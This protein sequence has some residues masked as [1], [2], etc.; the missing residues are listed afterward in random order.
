MTDQNNNNNNMTNCDTNDKY[1]RIKICSRCFHKFSNHVNLK[2]GDNCPRTGCPG[3]ISFLEGE[4]EQI[5][6][7]LRKKNYLPTM[8]SSGEFCSHG[9]ILRLNPFQC[10][11]H[12]PAFP[13]D[14]QPFH[15]NGAFLME[16][17]YNNTD[18]VKRHIEVED[19]ISDAK[20]DEE[21]SQLKKKID[22][23][24]KIKR[25]KYVEAINRMVEKSIVTGKSLVEDS[26][27]LYKGVNE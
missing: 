13:T 8:L 11:E 12:L 25:P 2:V 1:K 26:V 17:K 9:F 3:Y 18:P 16:R 19:A 6:I 4:L 5:F 24:F 10:L 7:A 21:I 22:I 15:D 20:T 14:F 23:C 27:K